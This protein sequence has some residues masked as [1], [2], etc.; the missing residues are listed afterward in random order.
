VRATRAAPPEDRLANKTFCLF[1]LYFISFEHVATPETAL[2][3]KEKERQTK[4]EKC[5]KTAEN[6]SRV[7]DACSVSAGV[8]S[9]LVLDE[10]SSLIFACEVH[11]K[12][13]HD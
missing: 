10:L 12:D 8:S 13:D 7:G 5:K 11:E 1:V 2:E 9:H 6:R 3:K 4:I